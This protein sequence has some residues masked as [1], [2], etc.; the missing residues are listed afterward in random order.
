MKFNKSHLLTLAIGAALGI[1]GV[2]IVTNGPT[3]DKDLSVVR[4]IS[5][6]QIKGPHVF[7]EANQN[8]NRVT[9][10]Q[11]QGGNDDTLN[12]LKQVRAQMRKQMDQMMGNAF[13]ASALSDQN[14]GMDNGVKITEGEDAQYKYVKIS[15]E[16]VDQDSL[17]VQIKNGMVSISGRVEK[18]EG[19]GKSFESTSISSFSQ[20]FN[21]PSGVNDSDVKMVSEDNALVLKFKK[22]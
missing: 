19:D 20:S 16:G 10:Q 17:D 11:T 8:K 21:T 13:S 12:Q 6:S 18:K 2:L 22:I 7:K 1:G 15:G 5:H 9:K 4:K 14:M 3:I